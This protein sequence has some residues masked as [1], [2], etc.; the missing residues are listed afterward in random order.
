MWQGPR[1][2]FV[3]GTESVVTIDALSTIFLLF[4]L[5]SL[6]YYFSP[7]L[8]RCVS[9]LRDGSSVRQSSAP[10][11]QVRVLFGSFVFCLVGVLSLFHVFCILGSSYF[12]GI[13]V[14][15]ALFAGYVGI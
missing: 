10:L 8:S 3:A 11:Q 12:R 14:S 2:G 6:H 7:S 5:A 9:L 1:L 13:R 15:C 4:C